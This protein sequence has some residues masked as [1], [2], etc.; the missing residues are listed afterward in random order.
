MSYKNIEDTRRYNNKWMKE[1]C[2]ILC[3]NCHREIKYGLVTEKRS[4]SR[5]VSH[6]G[7]EPI[8]EDS[9]VHKDEKE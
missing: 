5:N 3:A 1:K 2:V 9:G 6:Q 7:G 4:L 8:G